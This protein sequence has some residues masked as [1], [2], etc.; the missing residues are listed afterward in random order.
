MRKIYIHFGFPRTGTTTLQNHFFPKHSQISYWGKN[1]VY[2]TNRFSDKRFIKDFDEI[3]EKVLQLNDVSFEQQTNKIVK[4]LNSINFSNEKINVISDEYI[5]L[6]KV[7][8]KYAKKTQFLRS[9]ERFK[10]IFSK[11][12]IETYFFFT[13]RN[14]TDFL[15]S[16]YV[17]TSRGSGSKYS[18]N[19]LKNILKTGKSDNSY[20]KNLFS[21]LK[22]FKIYNKL[23]KI[24]EKEERVKILLY[25]KF[26]LNFEKYVVELSEFLNID[27]DESK[28]LL[29][30]KIEN[31]SIK[32]LRENIVTNNKFIVLIRLIIKNL[33]SPIFLLKNLKKKTKAF[34]CFIFI[35]KSE[36]FTNQKSKIEFIPKKDKKEK[37][38]HNLEIIK[39]QKNLIKNFFKEDT[40]A[41]KK[42]LNL[43]LDRY[44]Y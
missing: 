32:H 39:N 1:L 9:L 31:T 43:D 13:I 8:Y 7:H 16:F 17:A 12:N 34:F 37:I 15:K 11:I 27:I 14:Q 25:E 24:T 20:L 4:K 35:T 5:F 30:G 10:N 19:E 21:N 23:I 6:E 18:L 29:T 26:A 38:L 22:Y 2:G 44:D 28:K 36:N 33:K 41:L 42:E 3:Y 40:Q